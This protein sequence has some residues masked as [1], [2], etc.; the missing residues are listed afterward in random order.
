MTP[1]DLSI[2]IEL[3]H[4]ENYQ[5]ALNNYR[6][7]YSNF[8]NLDVW[9]YYYFFLWYIT[10]EDLPLGLQEFVESNNLAK[11]LSQI[12]HEGLQ[13]YSNKP[14]ALFLLGYTIN[15]FPYYFGDYEKWEM[16][17]KEMLIKASQLQPENKIYRMVALGQL[18]N[19]QDNPEYNQACEIAASEVI[20][21][22]NGKGLMNDYFKEVLIRT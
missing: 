9:K 4:H 13:K 5:N 19:W 21:T 22:Y 8:N 16:K 14:E 18:D 12:G 7:L 15:L 20:L 10:V 11:E 3:E 17:G 1:S 2:I 6:K